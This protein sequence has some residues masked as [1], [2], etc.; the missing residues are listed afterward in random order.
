MRRTG[1]IS[2]THTHT[3]YTTSKV[4]QEFLHYLTIFERQKRKDVPVLGWL[5]CLT[6][7]FTLEKWAGIQ[8]TQVIAFKHFKTK[9]SIILTINEK[10][11][12]EQQFL[13]PIFAHP[14]SS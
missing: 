14:F 11:F 13:R 1:T 3:Q 5:I 4:G 9:F 8:E 2:D 6:V 10:C 12:D 7:N